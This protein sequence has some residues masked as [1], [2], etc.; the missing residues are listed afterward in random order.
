MKVIKNEGDS[1]Q[2]KNN[3][4]LIPKSVC[5]CVK[6]K[7]S[8]ILLIPFKFHLNARSIKHISE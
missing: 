6:C 1:M 7:I 8:V 3:Y 5:V 2:K 4:K